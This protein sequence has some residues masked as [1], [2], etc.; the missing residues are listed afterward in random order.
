M[1]LTQ[2]C[3]Q[4][5]FRRLILVWLIMQG[6]RRGFQAPVNR[7]S[8]PPLAPKR[9]ERDLAGPS[10]SAAAA[11][12]AVAPESQAGMT[13]RLLFQTLPSSNLNHKCEHK[14]FQTLLKLSTSHISLFKPLIVQGDLRYFEGF[15][16]K[17]QSQIQTQIQTNPKLKFKLQ[18]QLRFKFKLKFK[19]F[20][21]I[22]CRWR[23][24][25]WR[26]WGGWRGKLDLSCKQ[27]RQFGPCCSINATSQHAAGHNFK[28]QGTKNVYQ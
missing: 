19:S 17:S 5:L 4:L 28:S 26:R 10:T 2:E 3:F 14:P 15:P 11:V 25:F 23:R 6:R 1:H 12:A 13:K 9:S 20:S 21:C 8:R 27:Y 7:A 16:F 22:R 18:L 24:G